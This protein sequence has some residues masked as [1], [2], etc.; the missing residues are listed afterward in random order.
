MIGL[1]G[2]HADSQGQ[3]SSLD[4]EAGRKFDQTLFSALDALEES[5]AA[6]A[7]IGGIAASGL[8]RP[9]STQ[10]ID[11]FVRPEDAE[12]VLN[13]FARSGFRTEQTNPTWLFKAFKEGVLVDIIFRSEGGFYY[14]DEMR[15]RTINASYHG[16]SVRLVSPED[17]ILI[18]C[19]VYSEEGPHHWHDALSV[20]SH[21]KLDWDYLLHRSRKASRRLLALLIYAQSDDI[22][23]PNQVIHRLYKNVF[24]DGTE[25]ALRPESVA[26]GPSRDQI[27]SEEAY[28][29]MRIREAFAQHEHI[30]ALDVDLWVRGKVIHLRGIVHTPEQRRSITDL[31]RRMA[32]GYEINDQL[33]ATEWVA[34][35]EIKDIV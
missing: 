7:L 13:V 22:W 14:D 21:A 18:K 24:Q 23:V 30:G 8:G 6:Y 4:T 9:R 28:L 15:E 11:V 25:A 17:F 33:Q 27:P 16:R 2:R 19:A 1:C 12:A 32:P 20:L 26:A 29:G 35:V 10:D 34:P 31:L 3:S 5:K